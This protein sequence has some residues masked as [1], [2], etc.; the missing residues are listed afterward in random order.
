[1]RN[2]G[3]VWLATVGT[4]AVTTMLSASA[5]ASAPGAATQTRMRMPGLAPHTASLFES[6][7]IETDGDEYGVILA[8]DHRSLYFVRRIERDRLERIEISRFGDLGWDEPEVVD[9]SGTH[10]DK[11]PFVAPN[12]VDLY[13]AST[14][15]RKGDGPANPDSDAFDLWVVEIKRDGWGKPRHLGDQINSSA[16][17]NY[18]SVS[19]AG[20]LYFSSKRPGGA[21]GNDLYRARL[22][23][24]EYMEPENLRALNSDASDADPYIAP[25]ESFLIFSSTRAGGHGQGDLF[26]SFNRDGAW[27]APRNMGEAV[28]GPGYEYTPYVSTPFNALFFSRDWGEVLWIDTSQLPLRPEE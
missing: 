27:S 1:M 15:P 13:F 25:D 12:G 26:V 2:S 9:F 14:R 24:R 18:P 16:Y 4:V 10:F 11:E 19:S 28:N 22:D 3:R 23:G 20:T 17:E 8:P 7:L 5:A 21:G 6:G